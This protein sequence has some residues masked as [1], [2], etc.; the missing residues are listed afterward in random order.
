LIIIGTGIFFIL[1]QKN[2]AFYPLIKGKFIFGI[3]F[4]ISKNVGIQHDAN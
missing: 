3:I 2:E 4:A 1:Y